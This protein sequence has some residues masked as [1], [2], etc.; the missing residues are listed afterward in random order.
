M[1]LGLASYMALLALL[2]LLAPSVDPDRLDLQD[3]D[4]A[5][6]ASLEAAWR[7]SWAAQG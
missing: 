3:L 7:G 1:A 5:E 4:R 6:E 2:A